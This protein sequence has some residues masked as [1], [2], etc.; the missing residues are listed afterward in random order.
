MSLLRNHTPRT[1]K[2]PELEQRIQAVVSLMKHNK[3]PEAREAYKS[4]NQNEKDY[5]NDHYSWVV[6]GALRIRF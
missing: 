5:L 4:L 2:N 6:A 1:Q 3:K